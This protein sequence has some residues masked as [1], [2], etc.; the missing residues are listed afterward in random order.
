[1]ESEPVTMATARGLASLLIYF[2]DGKCVVLVRTLPAHTEG[3]GPFCVGF[4]SFHLQSKDVLHGF[5]DC[6]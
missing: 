4:S 3:P 5:I 2:D 1:M 6:P